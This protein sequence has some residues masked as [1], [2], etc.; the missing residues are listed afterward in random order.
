MDISIF[1]FPDVSHGDSGG[2]VFQYDESGEPV[3][4]GVVTGSDG[5]GISL[6]P[7]IAERIWQ[8]Y[9]LISFDSAIVF[10]NSTEPVFTSNTYLPSITDD[11]SGDS[12]DDDN[13]DNDNDNDDI[14]DGKNEEADDDDSN[15]TPVALIIGSTF[16]AVILITLVFVITIAA[17]V[18]LRNR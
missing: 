3:L 1:L 8:H 18:N 17:C 2:P 12:D 6:Y 16:G 5:C 13:D 7:T 10:T 14:S 15:P 9:K 11:G 4:V